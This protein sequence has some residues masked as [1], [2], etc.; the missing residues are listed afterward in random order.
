MKP[1][2]VR[3]R[4]RAICYSFKIVT[5]RKRK[6]KFGW[7]LFL[8]WQNCLQHFTSFSMDSLCLEL[9]KDGQGQAVTVAAVSGYILARPG[10][11]VAARKGVADSVNRVLFSVGHRPYEPFVEDS[12]TPVTMM[13][14]DAPPNF[15]ER[16]SAESNA[17]SVYSL[18]LF[19]M[20]R[21][22]NV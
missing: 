4:Q 8:N 19:L 16:E 15:W 5:C 6:P 17:R 7:L 9:F 1:G 21:V 2:R 14:P 13:R 10:A 3:D 22:E 12:K 11:F 20:I 18:P